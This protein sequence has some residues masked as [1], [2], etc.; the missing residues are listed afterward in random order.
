MANRRAK[1]AFTLRDSIRAT[2]W[3]GNIAKS[4]SKYHVRAVEALRNLSSLDNRQMWCA[5]LEVD[6]HEMVGGMTRRET[7]FGCDY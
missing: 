1:A 5:I 6:F 7:R 3:I 4:D 2:G